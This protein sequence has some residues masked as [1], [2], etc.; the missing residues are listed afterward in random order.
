MEDHLIKPVHKLKNNK[1]V[2]A[3]M[4]IINSKEISMKM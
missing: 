1:I 2:K 3:T 4:I